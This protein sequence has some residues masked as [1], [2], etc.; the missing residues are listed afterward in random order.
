MSQEQFKK[1]KQELNEVEKERTRVNF[2]KAELQR[3]WQKSAESQSEYT[4]LFA[5]IS[6]IALGA[7]FIALV[8]IVSIP[9]LVPI[10][11]RNFIIAVLLV[12]VVMNISIIWLARKHYY[13]LLP[14]LCLGYSIFSFAFG[15]VFCLL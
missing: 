10:A 7:M 3:K 6:M 11:H 2:E 5:L 15:Y 12:I 4:S 1:L 14:M 13:V 8:V 9:Q